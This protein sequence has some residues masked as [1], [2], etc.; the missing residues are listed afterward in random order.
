M[1]HHA[2]QHVFVI[3]D[4]EKCCPQRDLGCQVKRVTRSFL[5]GLTQLACRPI[6]GI[7][8]I[9]TEVG[10]LGRHHHLERHTVNVG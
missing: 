1:V 6:G 10:P 8:D 3:A 2:H 9:P 5:D 7:D 4:A